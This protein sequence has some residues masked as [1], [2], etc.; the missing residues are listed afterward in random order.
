VKINY[1]NSGNDKFAEPASQK[2]TL[3]VSANAKDNL[4]FKIFIF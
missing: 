1:S 3:K 4:I 2:I